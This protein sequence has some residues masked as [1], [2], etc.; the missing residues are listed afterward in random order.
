MTASSATNERP[1]GSVASESIPAAVLDSDN[2]FPFLFRPDGAARAR[3]AK[4]TG[5]VKVKRLRFDGCVVAAANGEWRLSGKLAASV[6]QQCVFSLV[7][8]KFSVQTNVL[9]RYLTDAGRLRPGADG[10]MPADDSLEPLPDTIDLYA[11][12]RET[13]SLELPDYP[14]AKGAGVSIPESEADLLCGADEP[15]AKPFAG[16]APLKKSLENIQ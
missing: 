15:A 6:I 4:E 12:A 9:R 1:A 11:I 7:P 14:R 5:A 2:V 10:E 8:V 16:L 3:L 13:L